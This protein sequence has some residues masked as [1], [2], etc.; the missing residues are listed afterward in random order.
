MFGWE[1]PPFS[2][3]GLGTH[4]YGLTRSMS[5]KGTDI[6]FVM[7]ASDIDIEH[8]FVKIIQAGKDRLVKIGSYL[9]PYIESVASAVSMGRRGKGGSKQNYGLNLF[10]EVGRYTVLAAE[11]VKDEVFDIIHCHDWMTFPA[12]IRAKKQSGRPLVVSVHSTEFD[13][14]PISPNTRITHMEWEGMYEADRIIT[15][16]NYMKNIIMEKYNVPGEKISVVYNAVDNDEYRGSRIMFGSGEK[17]VLFL[18]RLVMQ[19]GA[20]YFLEAAQKV[21]EEEDSVRFLVVGTGNMMPELIEKSIALG[22]GDKVH[23]TGYVDSTK[24]YYKMADLY[25]MPSVSEPF[26]IT[27]LEALASGTPIIISKNSGV[28]E[29]VNHC[30]T[31]DFWDVNELANK[32]LGVIKYDCLRGEMK[33]NGYLEVQK[34]N[35][36]SIADDT[37]NVYSGTMRNFSGSESCTGSIPIGSEGGSA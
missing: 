28:S 7:P 11:S 27:A 25:V 15:V 5:R 16:S 13:R 12:G 2:S 34:F 30:M 3:G 23:F 33:H 36:D 19:K 9:A 26:G 8:G 29:V 21:L 1:F 14:S 37:L 24:E 22:I 10:D 4:C 31:V 20:D 18:G 17:L 32:M 35:W 6:T